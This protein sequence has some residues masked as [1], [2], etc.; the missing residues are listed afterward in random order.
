MSIVILTLAVI[1]LFAVTYSLIKTMATDGYGR[2]PAPRSHVD[3]F[4]P[5]NHLYAV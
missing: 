1:A 5:E 3:E 4:D 2:T